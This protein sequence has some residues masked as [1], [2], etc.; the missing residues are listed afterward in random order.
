M[1]TDHHHR[2]LAHR[3]GSVYV[4]VLGL[5]SMSVVIGAGAIAVSRLGARSAADNRDWNEATVLAASGVEAA[6]AKMNTDPTWRVQLLSGVTSGPA[7][8]GRGTMAYRVVDETDNDLSLGLL[9][10]VR[11]YGV[12]ASGNAR[13]YF[14]A[15]AAPAGSGPPAE[16]LYCAAYAAAT[17]TFSGTTTFTGGAAASGVTA[18]VNL[19]S[20]VKGRV[21]SLVVLPLGAITGGF[22]LLDLP[23]QMPPPSV[24]DLYAAIA[25]P[26]PFGSISSGTMRRDVISRG[27]NPWGFTNA[28]GVYSVSVPAGGTLT[29]RECR[30][31]CTLVVTL[32]SGAKL[33][34]SSPV[35]WS[36]ASTSAPML[37][38]KSAGL[39]TVELATGS[40]T[41][42]ETS[43]NI[44][45]NPPHTPYQGAADT[46][47]TGTYPSRLQGLIHIIGGGVSTSIKNSTTIVGSVVSE[48]SLDFSGDAAITH[49]PLLLTSPPEGYSA[50]Y[51]RMAAVRGS[52]RWESALP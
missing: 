52:W 16:A 29:I 26:I 44:N 51:G 11:I 4:L 45:Y 6:I 38:V 12:G 27:R 20:T 47:V 2:S 7:A 8:M 46:N 5:A 25:T 36:P 42:N 18:T 43:G 21:E 50:S 14:S 41:L 37:I 32:G 30:L 3:R 40:A 22:I 10:P 19:L 33:V 15:V 24:F 31:E 28:D 35:N 48:G 1:A 9:G 17:A 34:V 23:K 13:R 49:D 39:A